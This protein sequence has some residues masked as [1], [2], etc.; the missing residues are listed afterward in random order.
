MPNHICVTC[1]VQYTEG[2]A[3]PARCLICEDERQFVG[4]EGQRWTTMEELRPAYRNRFVD[5][6]PNLTRIGTEPAFGIAQHAFLIRSSAGN[7]LWDCITLIDDETVETVGKLGGIAA[8]AISHPHFY[9]AMVEWSRA[10]GDAPVYLHAADRRWVTRRDP[11]IVFWEGETRVLGDGLTLIHAD[12]HF[13][14]SAVL[15]WADGAKGRGVLLSSDTIHVVPDRRWVA[16][17]YSYPN[18]IPLPAVKVRRVVDSVEPFSFERI[19]GPWP[20]RVVMEGGKA[21]VR[22]SAERY[23]RAISG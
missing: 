15:H 18:Y 4:W 8:I 12:G 16:F 10:F 7:V 6:E 5:T 23:L 2:K 9:S 20:G 14:G 3:P 13:D 17:M 19:Y 21:A 22:R 11:A 1:G